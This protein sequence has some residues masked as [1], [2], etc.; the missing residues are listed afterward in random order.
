MSEGSQLIKS[1]LLEKA[2]SFEKSV[3]KLS[4]KGLLYWYKQMTSCKWPLVL[5]E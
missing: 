4:H 3:S 1:V 5:S 2:F